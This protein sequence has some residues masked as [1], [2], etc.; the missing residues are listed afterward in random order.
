MESDVIIIGGGIIG[1]SLARELSRYNLNIELL[2]KENDIAWGISKGNSG[3]IHAG[4]NEKIGSLKG[5]FDIEGNKMFDKLAKELDFT[6]IRNGALILGFNEEDINTL[7]KLKDNGDALGIEGLELLSKEQIKEIEP[8]ISI[9]V[10]GALHAKTSG[11]VNPY[12]VTIAFA[13][14]ACKNGVNFRLNSEVVDIKENDDYYKVYLKNGELIEG[15]IVINA[16]GINS[17]TINNMINEKKYEHIPVKGEYLVFDKITGRLVNH[18]LFQVPT[19]ISKGV[20]VTPTVDGN[21]LI[22]P[23]ANKVDCK[24]CV[25]T[26]KKTIAVILERATKSIPEI[27][28]GRTLNTFAG[29]RPHLEDS[30]FIIEEAGNNKNFISLVGVE[31]PGLTAAP[32]IAKYIVNLVSKKIPME[33]KSNFDPYRKRIIR[34]IDLTV[35]EKNKLIAKNPAY[36]KIICK[37]ELVTEGEIIDSIRRPLGA[38]TIDGVN[39]RTRATQGGCQG[40]GCQLPISKILS[41]ELNINIS[42]IKKNVD[43]STVIGIKED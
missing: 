34:F 17:D 42:D 8:N 40:I 33:L 41:K 21:L 27:P 29:V 39:Q 28:L 5:K 11:I 18:T 6:F 19:K 37:C 13:E 36:G 9:Y 12:E 14:N 4:Y 16:A 35:E 20:L 7:K 2:E 22:G 10:E 30:D 3:I 43:G 32:A 31:S 1:C 15:K 25:E 24:E 23:T 38:T 26:D